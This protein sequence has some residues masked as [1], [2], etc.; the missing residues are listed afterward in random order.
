[1]GK[2]ISKEDNVIE[3]VLEDNKI[4][5]L[6]SRLKEIIKNKS[7]LHFNINNDNYLI[8]TS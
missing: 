4:E 7:R 3:I 1:M 8:N 2:I 6:I 5:E